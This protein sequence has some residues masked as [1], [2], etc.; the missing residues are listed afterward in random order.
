MS[1]GD[2]TGSADARV[3]VDRGLC[4]QTIEGFG[5]NINPVGHWRAGSLKP[6]LDLLMDELGATIF[7][8]DPYGTCTWIGEDPPRV[9]PASLEV[10][11][12]GADFTEA[13]EAARYLLTRGAR[14]LLN[15]SGPVPKWMCEPDGK[16]LRDTDA[17][18]ELLTS[19]VTW[20]VKEEGLSLEWFGPFNETDIG[21]PEG[22]FIAPERGCEVIERLDDRLRETLGEHVPLVAFDQARWGTNYLSVLAQRSKARS[23]VDVIGMHCYAEVD[24]DALAKAVQDVE[25][26]SGEW[27]LT[28]YGNLD[29]TGEIEWEVCR[30]S[31]ERVLRALTA[32]ASAALFWDAYDNWHRHEGGW[33]LYGLLRTAVRGPVYEYTLKK[34]F[35]AARHLYRFAPR[36][37]QRVGTRC[38]GVLAVA[39]SGPLEE[40]GLTIVGMNDDEQARLLSV[41]VTDGRRIERPA[42]LSVTTESLTN[43]TLFEGQVADQLRIRLPGRS[44]FT[45]TTVSD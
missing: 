35:W 19:L 10:A 28:E 31:T 14:I 12:R 18:V 40:N 43:E 8:F 6:V 29:R 37:W 27:W 24:T 13:W 2:M 42:R 4:H 39:F 33:T 21:P 22:P 17:Y 45:L 11:Y 9:T 36:G 16:S 26:R 44:I 30:T 32:G 1:Q 34:R 7:R 41:E 38:E 20:Y 25:P 23:A 5:V 15:V 3:A